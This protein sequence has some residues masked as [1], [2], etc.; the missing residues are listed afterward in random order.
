MT[1]LST[2][3][4]PALALG[5]VV[6]LLFILSGYTAVNAVLK[7][8]LF[9]AHVRALGVALPYALANSLFGGSA[10][11]VALAFKKAGAESGFYAYVAIVM[12]IA[13]IVVINTIIDTLGQSNRYIIT[14]VRCFFI[15]FYD[16]I[17]NT[18]SQYNKVC[19]TFFN[20]FFNTFKITIS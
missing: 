19:N 3:A 8:E 5:L 4:S 20:A 15:I 11:Y 6:L 13:F 1:A 17:N 12:S 14:L 16:K 9:P 10:E 7:A 18:H 2:A